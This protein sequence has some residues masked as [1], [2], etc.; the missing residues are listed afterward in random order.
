MTLADAQRLGP[1]IARQLGRVSPG[2]SALDAIRPAMDAR[3]LHSTKRA[4]E[5]AAALRPVLRRLHERA[6]PAVPLK[7]F[8]LAELIYRDPGVRSM[9]DVDLL[10]PLGRIRDAAAVFKAGG[11]AFPQPFDWETRLAVGR[12]LPGLVSG[13]VTVELHVDLTVREDVGRFDVAGMISRAQPVTIAGSPAYGLTTEDLLLHVAN[14]GLGQHRAAWGVTCLLDVAAILARAAGA[15]AWPVVVTRAR[16]WEI[17]RPVALALD[18]SRRLFAADV[19][20]A[21]VTALVPGGV[22]PAVSTT[23]IVQLLADPGPEGAQR[24]DRRRSMLLAKERPLADRARHLVRLLFPDRVALAGHFNL[25]L[26][27]RRL[28]LAY[29]RR[30]MAL[31]GRLPMFI[32]L[33]RRPG[34]RATASRTDALDRWYRE[35]A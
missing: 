3:L 19:P 17:A 29:P 13:H 16:E 6:I 31:A 35:S 4:L 9:V 25:P 22:P 12:H 28:W 26:E 24:Y 5:R 27:S 2:R 21:V 7:G 1:Y 32:R 23:A 30:L 15:V 8:Y 11:F 18:L 10:V 33:A 20:L 34:A 14:H